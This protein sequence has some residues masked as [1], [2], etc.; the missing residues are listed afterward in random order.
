M[1]TGMKLPPILTDDDVNLDIAN[2]VGD[3]FD[4]ATNTS[5][6]YNGVAAKIASVASLHVFIHG[7]TVIR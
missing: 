3:S 1:D 7:A 6:I 4:G 5:G 2:C